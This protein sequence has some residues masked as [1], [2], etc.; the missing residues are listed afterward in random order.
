MTDWQ[1]YEGGRAKGREAPPEFVPWGREDDPSGYFPEPGLRDAVNVALALGQPLLLTGDPGTGKT[2]LAHSLAHDLGVGRALVFDT[3]T[4]T[5]AQDLFY[6]YDAIRHFHDAQVG[7]SLAVEAKGEGEGVETDASAGPD[8]GADAVE[9]GPDEGAAEKGK[10]LRLTDYVHFE[11][12]GLAILLAMDPT[13]VA[14]FLPPRLRGGPRRRSVVLV[15]EIDKAP[16]DV[17]NDLLR[18]I[19]AMSFR[20]RVP[21]AERFPHFEAEPRFRP[22]VVLTSNSEKNLPDAFLRRC[23][24]YNLE[25]PKQEQLREIVRRRLAPPPGDAGA[26]AGGDAPGAAAPLSARDEELVASAVREFYAIR[27]LPLKK[28][29]AT[30]E[31]LAWVRLLRERGLDAVRDRD[32][33]RRGEMAVSYSVLAKTLEDLR[34]LRERIGA[35]A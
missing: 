17:P 11:A 7:R 29:P 32:S 24:F 19:E 25:F 26:P 28:K 33:G 15:D 2:Q 3:K 10:G 9:D 8:G 20:V 4:T 16:R 31:F 34:L 18:E 30:A 35:A 23:V 21:G 27:E 22:I 1:I 12:L 5:T 6:R 14:P 13:M